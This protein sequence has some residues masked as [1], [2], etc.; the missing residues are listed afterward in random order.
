MSIASK[1]RERAEALARYNAWEKGLAD[2]GSSL[3]DRLAW[4]EEAYELAIKFGS[5]K[6]LP[7]T[8]E[9]W[10]EEV[11]GVRLM[12]ERLALLEKRNG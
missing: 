10:R 3:A 12:H 6:P 5:L 8:E 7:T 2:D 4:L 1:L 11:S 9:A